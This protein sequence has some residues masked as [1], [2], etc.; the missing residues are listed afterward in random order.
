MKRIL[1]QTTQETENF[2]GDSVLISE[3]RLKKCDRI[4]YQFIQFCKKLS[5]RHE[6][7][8]KDKKKNEEYNKYEDLQKVIN[9]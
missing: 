6:L 5:T 8:T 3:E 1:D 2:N 4:V 7:T 9:T